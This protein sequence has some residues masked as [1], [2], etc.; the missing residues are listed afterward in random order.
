MD[1]IKNRDVSSYINEIISVLRRRGNYNV[2][3][4][5][6]FILTLLSFNVFASEWSSEFRCFTSDNKKPINVKL[7]NVY[8]GKDNVSLSYVKYE[9][10][11]VSIPIFLV[12]D[13][14]EILSE[15]RPYVNTTVWNEIVKGEINGAYTVISQGAR[16]Y[17][18]TYINKKGKQ[19]DFEENTDA[20][21]VE[22]KDC[23]W[24]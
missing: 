14:S 3:K 17:G 7:V 13:E 10:S 12:K 8:S 22:K 9:K 5:Y 19:F 11:P 20:Y 4:N 15:D 24:N 6:F 23:I 18:L 1:G 2:Y 16:V 21:D